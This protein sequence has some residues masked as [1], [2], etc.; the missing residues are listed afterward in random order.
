M[1]NAIHRM[2]TRCELLILPIIAVKGINR[3]IIRYGFLSLVLMSLYHASYN[4]YENVC[5]FR[6]L[7]ILKI[8]S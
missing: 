1:L 8:N 2:M 3:S 7:K 6:Y 5:L 4:R